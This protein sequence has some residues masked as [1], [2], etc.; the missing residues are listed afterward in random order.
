[1]L[2]WVSA[3]AVNL[4]R[5]GL[6]SFLTDILRPIHRELEVPS[7]FKGIFGFAQLFFLGFAQLSA[8]VLIGR[9]SKHRSGG[10]M[11]DPRMNQHSVKSNPRERAAFQGSSPE[12]SKPLAPHRYPFGKHSGRLDHGNPYTQL[13]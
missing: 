10:H 8:V 6:E 4:G 7:S 9:A 1:M 3:V 5:E 11:F 12:D 13:E 2:R